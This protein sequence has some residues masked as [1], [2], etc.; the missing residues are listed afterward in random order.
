MICEYEGADLGFGNCIL[1]GLF[2][3]F[4]CE[5]HASILRCDCKT[6]Q[7]AT[8]VLPVVC[9]LLFFSS[10]AD[11]QSTFPE[12]T[13]YFVPITYAQCTTYT[14][15]TTLTVSPITTTAN[16][17]LSQDVAATVPQIT[18]YTSV[19][20]WSTWATTYPAVILS[21]AEVDPVEYAAASASGQ[22]ANCLTAT[23]TTP[24]DYR[25]ACATGDR[26]PATARAGGCGE[27]NSCCYDCDQFQWKCLFPPC[28]DDR[29]GEY[30][31][32]CADG[33]DY[34]S[35]GSTEVDPKYTM[36]ESSPEEAEETGGSGGAGGGS[37]GQ[38][39]ASGASSTPSAGNDQGQ[40]SGVGG[41][42]DR[43]SMLAICSSWMGVVGVLL[44]T[45][46]ILSVSW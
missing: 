12:F 28:D 42:A 46:T 20:T 8:F 24:I 13:Q 18:A 15:G 37:N 2:C 16:V 26:T 35:D 11:A 9:S 38:S 44:M 29:V 5:H 4:S 17:R 3:V 19:S 23:H 30:G 40:T 6:F 39:S 33:V 7:M 10:H 41:N 14:D 34:L 43:L 31:W 32:R 45:Q 1:T 22:P 25:N 27:L 36:T 21:A